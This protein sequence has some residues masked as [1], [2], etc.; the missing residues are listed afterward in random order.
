MKI[1]NYMSKETEKLKLDI[2]KLYDQVDSCINMVRIRDEFHM[3]KI[4]RIIKQQDPIK[5]YNELEKFISLNDRLNEFQFI[6][7]N[8]IVTDLNIIIKNTN[9]LNKLLDNKE[10]IINDCKPFINPYSK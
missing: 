6:L 7:I 4:K 5:L 9:E 8:N 3:N 10:N 2:N 1:Y